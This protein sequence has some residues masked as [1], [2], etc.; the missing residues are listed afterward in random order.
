MTRTIAVALLA[1][2]FTTAPTA[3]TA[4]EDGSDVTA[5]TVVFRSISFD[6][7][8]RRIAAQCFYAAMSVVD[9]SWQHTVC[10]TTLLGTEP[11]LEGSGL[12]DA[13]PGTLQQKV[14]FE[15]SRMDEDVNVRAVAWV[16]PRGA[17]RR[18]SGSRAVSAD[19]QRHYLISDGY[20]A[21]LQAMLDN[22]SAEPGT[23]V[24][25]PTD[26]V[27]WWHHFDSEAEWRREAHRRASA[28]CNRLMRGALSYR[29]VMPQEGIAGGDGQSVPQDPAS[30]AAPRPDAALAPGAYGGVVVDR[31]AC[32]RQQEQV[33]LWGLAHGIQ[34]PSLQQY[35]SGTPLPRHCL[36]GVY[37]E[38]CR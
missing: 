10:G 14:A 27:G 5:A 18:G 16:E 31:E 35:R 32:D 15:L 36:E 23:G 4:A 28:R 9:S 6:E 2:A 13:A 25:Q 22:I 12:A 3:A 24:M 21:R 30:P 26:N 7:V 19:A 29:A 38:G 37:Q 1:L 8:K 33:F 11:F 17:A 34:N 20:R